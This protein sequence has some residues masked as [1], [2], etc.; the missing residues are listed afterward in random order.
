MLGDAQRPTELSA[1]GAGIRVRQL[2]DDLARDASL[3]LSVLQRVGLDAFLVGL[4]IE[5]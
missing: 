3:A 5:R 2:P 1:V 4:E